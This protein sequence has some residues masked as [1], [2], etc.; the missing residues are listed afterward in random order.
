MPV[1]ILGLNK[2]GHTTV[3]GVLMILSALTTSSQFSIL[4]QEEILPKLFVIGSSDTG[5][6]EVLL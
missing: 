5:T 6:K 4:A 2:V 1:K 3:L